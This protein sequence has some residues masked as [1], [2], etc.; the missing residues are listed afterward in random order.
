MDLLKRDLL[1][2][3]MLGTILL[4]VFPAFYPYSSLSYFAPCL[5]ICMYRC[6]Y[7]VA[8]WMALMCGMMMDLLM[9][10]RF[11]IHS[12]AY[13]CVM[14]V[15]YRQKRHFFSDSLL[16]LPL[17]SYFFGLLSSW[18][19][20]LIRYLEGVRFLDGWSVVDVFGMAFYDALYAFVFFTLPA[21]FIRRKRRV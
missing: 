5:V 18:V 6:S 16:T 10:Q 12:C 19:I 7:A 21:V 9:D 20:I 4:L 15:L 2:P 13:V 1:V 3:F 17:M 11:G 14:L 8:L